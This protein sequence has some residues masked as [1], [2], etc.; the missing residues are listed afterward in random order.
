MQG[1]SLGG[2]DFEVDVQ[3]DEEPLGSV[4]GTA[5]TISSPYRR[6]EEGSPYRHTA[7]RLSMS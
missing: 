6:G 3:E 1:F 5:I 2:T 7:F 4:P